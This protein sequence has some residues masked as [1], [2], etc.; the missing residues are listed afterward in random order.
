[1]SN[2]ADVQL[3]K[4]VKI[5]VKLANASELKTMFKVIKEAEKEYSCNC[6]LLEI[7]IG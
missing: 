3:A 6:T 1:M 7:E 4:E 5:K 2:T